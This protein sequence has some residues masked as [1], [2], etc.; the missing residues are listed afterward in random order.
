MKSSY[1]SLEKLGLNVDVKCKA[2]WY[3]NIKY[4]FLTSIWLGET[5]HTYLRLKIRVGKGNSN[6]KCVLIKF[7]VPNL[8]TIHSCKSEFFK[9]A[10]KPF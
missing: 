6:L 4:I 3:T 7:A 9:P 5:I 1:L 8:V 2:F 10:F